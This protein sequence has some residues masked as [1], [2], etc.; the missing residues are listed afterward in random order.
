[1]PPELLKPMTKPYIGSG[2]PRYAGFWRRL[3]A[4]SIDFMIFAPVVAANMWLRSVSWTAAV[5]VCVPLAAASHV[6]DVCLHAR[7]GQ[8]LGK[9]VAGIEVRTV[10][11]YPIFWRDALR[12]SSVGIT[13]SAVFAVGYISAMLQISPD[14]YSK[15]AWHE[16]ARLVRALNPTDWLSEV[17]ALWFW[18]EVVVLLF[19]RKKRALHD[20][21]AG[22]VVVHCRKAQEDREDSSNE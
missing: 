17:A 2:W 21:I 1:M 9:M 18:S 4:C 20:Y 7:W 19:N 22:T 12:R 10:D 13:F 15:L 3:L 5:L 8:T 6:Y 11:D 16:Q 14:Q